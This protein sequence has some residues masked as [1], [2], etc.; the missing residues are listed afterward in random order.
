[1]KTRLLYPGSVNA[2]EVVLVTG[3][4]YSSYVSRACISL[5]E[6]CRT[7]GF[8]AAVFASSMPRITGQHADHI[9]DPNGWDTSAYDVA[10]VD[11]GEFLGEGG[12]RTGL[13]LDELASTR[14]VFFTPVAEYAVANKVTLPFEEEQ[15]RQVLDKLGGLFDCPV[16]LARPS[17][18][19]PVPAEMELH[20]TNSEVLGYMERGEPVPSALVEQREVCRSAATVEVV[21]ALERPLW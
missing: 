1:M 18:L 9:G 4:L 15:R 20:E 21:P 5:A 2:N 7:K 14:V 10:I 12:F 16:H 3:S 8:S 11:A 17:L 6:G 19:R 13:A